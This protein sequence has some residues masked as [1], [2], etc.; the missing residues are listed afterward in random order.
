M[1]GILADINAERN[2]VR[3][4]SHLAI[5]CLVRYLARPQT[6]RFKTL[7]PWAFRPDSSDKLI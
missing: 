5:G 7:L 3:A 4:C 2:P 1:Q 6:Y